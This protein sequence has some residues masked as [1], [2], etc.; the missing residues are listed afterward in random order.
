MRLWLLAIAI[1][2]AGCGTL[3]LSRKRPVVEPPA[4]FVTAY[5]GALVEIPL[6][7]GTVPRVC[8]AIAGFYDI[9]LGQHTE[10]LNGCALTPNLLVGVCIIV[11]DRE[12]PAIRR[13]ELAHCNGWTHPAYW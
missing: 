10:T 6:D 2:M 8:A 11:W 1:S 13:H 9:P 12:L 7:G 5:S 3:E 4:E